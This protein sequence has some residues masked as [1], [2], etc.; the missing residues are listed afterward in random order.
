MKITNWSIF[1]VMIYVQIF[2]NSFNNSYV[3]I[4]AG[5][6]GKLVWKQ[7][8][9]QADEE[10]NTVGFLLTSGKHIFVVNGVIYMEN[11][12]FY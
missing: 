3:D 12:Y 5:N 4:I 6:E 11:P 2:A 10:K 8:I 7:E 1:A 9:F